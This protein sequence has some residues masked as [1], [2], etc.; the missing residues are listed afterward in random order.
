MPVPA[1]IGLDRF[2]G[3][4]AESGP[5]VFRDELCCASI[6]AV[7]T[8]FVLGSDRRPYQVHQ[9]DLALVSSPGVLRVVDDS[10]DDVVSSL[11]YELVQVFVQLRY[12]KHPVV[13]EYK[14][15]Q[16]ANGVVI[17]GP[18]IDRG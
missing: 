1:V 5:V 15:R 18:A 14:S 4:V 6:A 8:C 9:I 16:N 3:E 2:R 13:L 12:A 7:P 11:A 10:T 17:V